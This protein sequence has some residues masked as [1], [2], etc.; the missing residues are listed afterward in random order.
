MIS[1]DK[2][3]PHFHKCT[4]AALQVLYQAVNYQMEPEEPKSEV[5]GANQAKVCPSSPFSV[6]VV[7][8]TPPLLPCPAPCFAP[9]TTAFH[10]P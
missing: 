3:Q 7:V 5:D 9:P 8:V 4:V 6:V 10:W 2:V 1:R